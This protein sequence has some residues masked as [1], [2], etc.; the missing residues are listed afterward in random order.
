MRL[1]KASR[2]L[3]TLL[4]SLTT[5]MHFI[6][7]AVPLRTQYR[8]I[9]SL[10][11]EILFVILNTLFEDLLGS[12]PF[13][14][15]CQILR[16]DLSL[17]NHR[18][19]ALVRRLPSLLLIQCRTGDI[20]LDRFLGISSSS[21]VNVIR[22]PK[23]PCEVDRASWEH[24][25]SFIPSDCARATFPRPGK[26]ISASCER[27]LRSYNWPALRK[28][29]I[30]CYQ[31]PISIG[32]VIRQLTALFLFCPIS[33]RGQFRDLFEVLPLGQELRQLE[34]QVWYREREGHGWVFHKSDVSDPF[35]L[36]RLASLFLQVSHRETTFNAVA[37]I[38]SAIIMP[39]I[40]SIS[41]CF[42]GF[43]DG[44]PADADLSIEHFFPLDRDYA[45]VRTFTIALVLAQLNVGHIAYFSRRHCRGFLIFRRCLYLTLTQ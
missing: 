19:R 26:M 29:H 27:I 17:V 6:E 20:T 11:D 42:H 18:F 15:K 23:H 8:G 39:E 45:S 37:A 14:I 36:P 21:G 30:N 5:K 24:W 22:E 25:V 34:V 33:T 1:R 32:S 28:L 7:R 44:F 16:T 2:A 10:P 3:E 43:Q 31:S 35:C 38:A 40:H 13:R 12:S 4:F 9:Q 41:I